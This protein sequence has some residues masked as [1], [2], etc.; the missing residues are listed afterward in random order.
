M[1]KFFRRIRQK[2]ISEKSFS[3]YLFYATGE[4]VLVVIGILIAL[5][6]NNWNTETI[7]QKQELKLVHRLNSDLKNNLAEVKDIQ[8]RLIINQQGIDSLISG[9]KKNSYTDMVPFYMNFAQRKTFFTNSSTAYQMIRN[10]MAN[11][12]SNDQILE[13]V[14]NLYEID[15]EEINERQ[16]QLHQEIDYLKRNFIFNEF[17]PAPRKM[18]FKFNDFD[19]VS[20]DLFVPID[21]NQLSNNKAFLNN[22]IQL[23]QS[24]DNRLVNLEETQ[25]KI[26]KTLETIEGVLKNSQ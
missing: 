6:I 17:E 23:R 21:F 19:K 10:G 16:E 11:Y 5:K 4:I 24:V 22:L 7:E 3:K 18:Q 13:P 8:S 20:N 25:E 14:L 1:I 9:L 26:E 2:L 12:F 15:F